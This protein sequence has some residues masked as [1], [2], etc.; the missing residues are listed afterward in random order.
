MGRCRLVA[1]RHYQNEMD[2]RVH[3]PQL[4]EPLSLREREVF[5][6][7]A[8]GRTNRAISQDL[9]VSLAT[10]KR[11]ITSLYDTLQVT[12]RTEAIQRGGMR[13]GEGTERTPSL[14]DRARI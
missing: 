3:H 13:N 6:G 5:H 9:G 2:G 1:S 10:V 4:T 14:S 12:S 7:I 8:A 11:D